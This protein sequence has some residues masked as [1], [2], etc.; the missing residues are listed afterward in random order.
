[1]SL[2]SRR[3]LRQKLARILSYALLL[4]SIFLMGYGAFMI[5][6]GLFGDLSMLLGGLLMVAGGGICWLA[7]VGLKFLTGED[8]SMDVPRH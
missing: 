8:A 5:Y 2:V 4:G 6:G 1:M 3:S 7:F